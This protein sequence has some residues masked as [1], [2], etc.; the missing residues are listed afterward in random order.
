[1]PVQRGEQSVFSVLVVE[2]SPQWR[3]RVQDL[4]R[5]EFPGHEVLLADSR[6]AA[7]AALA[8]AQ[9]QMVLLDLLLPVRSGDVDCRV[10][11][12][13]EVLAA[14]KR[15]GARV[16]ILS[17]EA[18][19][20]RD[21]LVEKGAD[22]FL[23]KGSR[24]DW[25]QETLP[26][27]IARLLGHLVCRS[28]AMR[29]LLGDIAALPRCP[30]AVLISGLPGSGRQYVAELLLRRARPGSAPGRVCHVLSEDLRDE[31]HT[32]G[33]DGCILLGLEY[34]PGL[35]PSLQVLLAGF[36]AERQGR[37]PEC[38]P[39]CLTCAC[40][41]SRLAGQAGLVPELAA[42]VSSLPLLEL[43]PPWERL[44]DV[45]GLLQA[46]RR[47][48]NSRFGSRVTSVSPAACE[49]VGEWVL[50]VRP[51][52]GWDAVRAAVDEGVRACSAGVLGPEHLCLPD[53]AETC[54][55]VWCRGGEVRRIRGTRRDELALEAQ[56]WDLVLRAAPDG[57]VTAVEEVRIGAVTRLVTD[58]RLGR[59][60]YLLASRPGE[61]V[62]V[63]R[64]KRAL[65]IPLATPTKRLIRELRALLDDRVVQARRSRFFA[66]HYSEAY[67]FRSDAD[68]VM[69]CKLRAEG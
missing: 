19:L 31:L 6:D 62:E 23:A 46:F 39:V 66:S 42:A 44:D 55:L 28:P 10:E 24:S 17:T 14:A 16:V 49:L 8:G 53:L 57:A 52:T 3:D 4:L 18:D 2:D 50:D 34:A 35:D 60:L 27:Q 45:P 7:L 38:G 36:V 65:D 20:T 59:L 15:L 48:A 58:R 11:C 21:F 32:L 5:T 12:G 22:D 26:A 25:Q 56:D 41:P 43:P 63:P 33:R 64:H 40:R 51:A 67:S 30:P 68:Y 37:V 9:P 1:M 69:V 54:E 47:D 13:E 61:Q 29:R